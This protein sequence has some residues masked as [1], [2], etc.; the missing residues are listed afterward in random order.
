MCSSDLPEVMDAHLRLRK[1]HRDIMR[2][3]GKDSPDRKLLEHKLGEVREGV[4]LLEKSMHVAFLD[5]ALELPAPERR[6]LLNDM[7][8][9]LPQGLPPPPRPAG[10]PP[11]KPDAPGEAEPPAPPPPER[12]TP[13]EE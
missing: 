6:R 7:R 3:L 2:E 11:A 5:T 13:P 4:E 10:D 9:Q 1:L 8:R 12:D